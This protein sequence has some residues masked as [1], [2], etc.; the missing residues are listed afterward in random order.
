MFV[1]RDY[2]KHSF[3]ATVM[4]HDGEI[5]DE[6]RYPTTAE[7]IQTFLTGLPEGSQLALEATGNWYAFYEVLEEHPAPATVV[8]AHPDKTRIIAEARIKTDTRSARTLAHLLRADCLPRAS[9]PPRAIRD[10]RETLRYRASLVAL[11]TMIKNKVHALLSKNGIVLDWSDI[12]GKHARQ[13]LAALVLRPGYR[14]ELDGYLRLAATL[15]TLI[16]EVTATIE[17]QVEEDANA[18]LLTT[19]P[20]IKYYSGLLIVSEI[21]EIAR[22]PSAGH[23][24]SYGGLVPSVYS[25]GGKTRHGR[26]TK[27]GS[28]WLR[29]I[30][31]QSAT[32]FRRDSARLDRLYQR[33]AARHGKPTA[34]VAVAREMVKIISVM[35]RDQ[36]PFYPDGPAVSGGA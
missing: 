3:Q 10:T 13:E 8:L 26:I 12:F 18:K 27:Q 35:L 11:K 23:L 30:L 9:I 4:T 31:V 15:E 17:V 5:V 36:R 14:Q 32:H 20:G 6:R 19:I 1:G 25:S 24:C 34:R 28:T 22:F 2:H 21:G 7:A 16:A 33:V 29:W